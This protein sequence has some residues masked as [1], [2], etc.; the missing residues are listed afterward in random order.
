M[1]AY[2]APP[3]ADPK[4]EIG[5][6]PQPPGNSNSTGPPSLSLLL[7]PGGGAEYCDELSICLS[8]CLAACIFQELHVQ[9]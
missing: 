6:N 9:T 8:V 2:Y 5:V 3:E 1:P 7:P 4:V